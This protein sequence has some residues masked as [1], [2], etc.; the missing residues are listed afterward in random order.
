MVARFN[1]ELLSYSVD[2]AADLFVRR[3]QRLDP[4][5]AGLHHV[6]EVD[7]RLDGHLD[8][9]FYGGS[10]SVALCADAAQTLPGAIYAG[11]R[12]AVRLGRLEEWQRL[13][14][15]AAALPADPDHLAQGEPSALQAL[16]SGG[17]HEAWAGDL[18]AV[19]AA[20]HAGGEDA[21]AEALAYAAGYHRWA[22]GPALIDGLTAGVKTPQVWLWALGQVDSRS[23]RRGLPTQRVWNFDPRQLTT[24]ASVKEL[25]PKC[26]PFE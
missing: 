2:E 18:T 5:D 21:L 16:A 14:E 10:A 22:V 12:T 17:A 9:L 4:P 26:P 11:T 20:V 19:A 23:F 8:V 3:C 7:A 15:R 1:E 13:A 24:C 6:L 25:P